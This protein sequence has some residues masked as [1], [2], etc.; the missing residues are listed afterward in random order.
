METNENKLTGNVHDDIDIVYD[1]VNYTEGLINR[2][3][4]EWEGQKLGICTEYMELR[5]ALDSMKIVAHEMYKVR[6]FREPKRQYG[7]LAEA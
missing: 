1:A 7:P 6:N 2:L 3:I 4:E 5:N